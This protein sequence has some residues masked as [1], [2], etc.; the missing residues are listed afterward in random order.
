MRYLLSAQKNLLDIELDQPSDSMGSDSVNAFP[1][2]AIWDNTISNAA[3][4]R[5]TQERDAHPRSTTLANGASCAHL[6]STRARSGRHTQ[7]ARSQ[8]HKGSI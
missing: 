5:G 3:A 6:W 7:Q 8:E 1:P 2:T 4:K